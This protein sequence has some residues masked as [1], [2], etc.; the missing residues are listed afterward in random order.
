MKMI[1]EGL[2]RKFP[3]HLKLV[4]KKFATIKDLQRRSRQYRMQ[5][6]LMRESAPFDACLKSW[7]TR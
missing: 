3:C 1:F 6:L 7:T 4:F 5:S 2:V